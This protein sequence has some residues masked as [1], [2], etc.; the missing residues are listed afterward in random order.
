[1]AAMK[2][3]ADCTDLNE[4]A[5]KF[6]VFTLAGHLDGIHCDSRRFNATFNDETEEE[7]YNR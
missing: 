1:M 6:V 2:K 5:G 4:F 7:L 3:L